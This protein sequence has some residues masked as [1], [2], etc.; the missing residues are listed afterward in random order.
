M[1]GSRNRA[2]VSV[3]SRLMCDIIAACYESEI[4]K[5][6]KGRLLDLGC[7]RVPLF[8]AYRAHVSENVCVDWENTLHTNE[9]L[10]FHCDLTGALPL[11]DGEFNTVLLSD[12]L[13]HIPNPDHLFKEIARLLCAGGRLLLTVPFFY[14]IHEA[15]HDY[16][17]YTEFALRRFAAMSG[18]NVLQLKPLGGAPEILA[19][20]IAKNIQRLPS[21]G[22][23]LAMLVQQSALAFIRTK[24]GGSLS[25]A[26][27]KYFPLGYFLVA[28]KGPAT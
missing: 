21:V 14:W 5:N 27:A 6:V 13:E 26:T 18:L 16:Y 15:P 1:T 8:E 4:G 9:H 2:D 17:R 7:G 20:I 3:G 11:K 28:E 22:N 25:M 10:D 12:V 24:P 23:P 19:D